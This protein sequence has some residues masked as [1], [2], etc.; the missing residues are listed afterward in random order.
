M[1]SGHETTPDGTDTLSSE[2]V[3]P[4]HKTMC[5]CGSL[6]RDHVQLW[7]SGARLCAIVGVWRKTMC[8]CTSYDFSVVRVFQGAEELDVGGGS[9]RRAMEVAQMKEQLESQ[10]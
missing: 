2:R 6:V 5:N 10:V 7:E 9:K 3:W 8:N 4:V 1:G